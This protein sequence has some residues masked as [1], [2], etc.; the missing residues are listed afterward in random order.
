[1]GDYNY[2]YITVVNGYK[3]TIF[4]RV[5]VIGTGANGGYKAN[6]GNWGHHLVCK[7]ILI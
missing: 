4:S 3:P 6:I 2:H 1:M 7:M 5:M